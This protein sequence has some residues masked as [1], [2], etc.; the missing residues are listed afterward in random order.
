MN[1]VLISDLYSRVLSNNPGKFGRRLIDVK[2]HVG[3]D[4][5]Q[6]AFDWRKVYTPSVKITP[7]VNVLELFF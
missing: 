2:M 7:S 4:V 6:V 5:N 3:R 1:V